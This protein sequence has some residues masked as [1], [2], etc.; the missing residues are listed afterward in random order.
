V[1]EKEEKD[2]I[3]SIKTKIKMADQT[4]DTK[5]DLTGCELS[6]LPMT[7]MNKT[8]WTVLDLSFNR[9][10]FYIYMQFCCVVARRRLIDGGN[11]DFRH[12]RNWMRSYTWR[13]CI[14]R[15]IKLK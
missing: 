13:S 12:G 8:D 9:F 15:G 10:G 1:K 3:A 2:A 14:W 4:G 11:L 5:I 6:L 7:V